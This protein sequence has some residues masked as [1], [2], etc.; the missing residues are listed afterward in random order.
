MIQ[1]LH[2]AGIGVIMDVVY[3]HTYN[4]NSCFNR[5]VPEYYYR[6]NADGTYSNQSGCSNDTASERAM[7]R[8][9]MMDMLQ[10]W[11]DE[12]HVDGY[13][14]DLMGIHD[15]ETMNLI[16]DMLDETDE[17][18][19]MYGEGWSGNTTLDPESCTGEP[20]L[21]CTQRNAAYTSE[22]IGFFNDQMRDALKGGVFDGPT[23]PGWLS[24]S[25]IH[26]PGISYGIR[27]NTVGKG[28]N[29]T[30]LA[31]D[32]CVSY[33]SCH[34]NNTL[35]DK[36]VAISHGMSA[37]YRAR[38]DD[39]ITQNKLS[40][41]ITLTSQGINLILAGEEMARSKDGDENSYSSSPTLNMIDWSLL[42]T[43]ADLVSYYK[44][45]MELRSAFSPFTASQKDDDDDSYKYFF[46]TSMAGANKTIAYT[47]ENNKE[48][49]WNKI[50]VMFNGSKG[51]T[52]Q[53]LKT[54]IDSGISEDTEWVIIANDKSAG[55]KKLGEVKGLK[56]KV[57]AF[58][59]IIA[60]EKS[61]YEAC[62]I[63]S[64]FSTVSINH[65]DNATGETF[66]TNTILGMPGEG[67]VAAADTSIPLKYDIDR[68]EGNVK[69]EFVKGDTDVN[70]Y[71]KRFTPSSFEVEN[72]DVDGD[73]YISIMDATAIQL[74]LAQM[75]VLD[76]AAFARGDYNY[77]SV[78]S[79]MDATLLQQFL[80]MEDVTVYTL[81]V[82]YVDEE[83]KAFASPFVKEFRLGEQYTTEAKESVFYEL[84]DK[85]QNAEGVITGNTTVTYVYKYKVD[86][87]K[88]HVK[89]NGDLTWDPF[90]WAWATPIGGGTQVNIYESWPGLQITDVD[91]NG[92]YTTEIDVPPEYTYSII[93]NNGGGIQ[94]DDYDGFSA[95]E[96]WVVIDDEKAIKN[97]AWISVYGDAELTDQLA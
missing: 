11:V 16:R 69:G 41:A 23:T 89:H 57:P 84:G 55:I 56:F 15:V 2:E 79:I 18:I 19:I 30:A 78:T 52:T 24:G 61:T 45:M 83:G 9:Y 97:G 77:D 94:T 8:R 32:Q 3:N 26:A 93:I 47:V 17:R 33:A 90:L 62:A 46:H 71:F 44:G 13:R 27:A 20:V 29:W 4:T 31:P 53:E 82:N 22:R 35:Y 48:G 73:G 88:V 95:K 14:F 12:Y 10:Y 42:E 28:S 25:M 59:A 40:S 43:N 65:I 81:T 68:V 49:E 74:H 72:G 91:E 67:Y 1:A 63:D 76:D 36:L 38:Y 85:P 7:F 96:I 37:D 64:K 50:A 51:L 66:K 58:S 5:T 86:S 6:M 21:P 80:A 70:Y 39:A 60:V 34:D 92:W 54:H 87:V 75:V